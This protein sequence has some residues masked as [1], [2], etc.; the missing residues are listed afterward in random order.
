M[1]FSDHLNSIRGSM[2]LG[3]ISNAWIF[4]ILYRTKRSCATFPFDYE[5]EVEDGKIL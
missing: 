4:G 2:H 1:L 3:T 5:D